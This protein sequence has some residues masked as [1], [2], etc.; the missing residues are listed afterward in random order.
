M[1]SPHHAG[2]TANNSVLSRRPPSGMPG[3]SELRSAFKSFTTTAQVLIGP[4]E[5]PRTIPREL[6]TTAS[7]FFNAALTGTFAEGLSQT[8][9]LP[10]DRPDVFDYFLY[11]MYTRRLDHEAVDAVEPVKPAYFWL[12]HL[13]CLV[14]KLGVNACKN[15]IVEKVADL[16]EAT[17]SVPTPTD[18]W[19]IFDTFLHVESNCMRRLIVD[20]F[21]WKRTDNLLDQHEDEWHPRFMRDLVVSLK[22]EDLSQADF[23]R[24]GLAPANQAA[25]GLLT[26][27]NSSVCGGIWITDDILHNAFHRFAAGH[28]SS[29]RPKT[30]SVGLLPF[31]QFKRHGSNV[32]GPLEFRRRQSGRRMNNLS[33]GRK[34]EVLQSRD[35][36]N[37]SGESLLDFGWLFGGALHGR[38]EPPK[39]VWK[40]PDPL[41]DGNV[42]LPPREGMR[43]GVKREHV[44]D[45]IPLPSW[46]KE[47][48]EAPELHEQSAGPT[49]P[50]FLSTEAISKAAVNPKVIKYNPATPREPIET[51]ESHE[52]S[53]ARF[54]QVHMPAEPTSKT[55]KHETIQFNLKTSEDPVGAQEFYEQFPDRVNL[56][57]MSKMIAKQMVTKYNSTTPEEAVETFESHEQPSARVTTESLSAEPTPTNLNPTVIHYDP[58]E[59]GH[60]NRKIDPHNTVNYGSPTLS[61][62]F[63]ELESHPTPESYIES[64]TGSLSHISSS[65]PADQTHAAI[66]ASKLKRPSFS[67]ID[68]LLARDSDKPVSRNELQDAFRTLCDLLNEGQGVDKHVD[69]RLVDALC[70]LM[71]RACEFHQERD[72]IGFFERFLDTLKELN[73]GEILRR[74][75]FQTCIKVAGNLSNLSTEKSVAHRLVRQIFILAMNSSNR[76]S[77]D[78]LWRFRAPLATIALTLL[79]QKGPEARLFGQ[80]TAM[81]E[82]HKVL[83]KIPDTAAEDWAFIAAHYFCERQ[84]MYRFGHLRRAR[85][86][87][88]WLNALSNY[89]RLTPI[90]WGSIL[91]PHL[92][93]AEPPSNLVEYLRYL[94]WQNISEFLLHTSTSNEMGRN[95]QHLLEDGTREFSVGVPMINA[96]TI[97]DEDDKKRP[98]EQSPFDKIRALLSS[99]SD[100]SEFTTEPELQR[101]APLLK[102]VKVLHSFQHS[103][104]YTADR[105]LDL[106]LAMHQWRGFMHVAKVISEKFHI[107]INTS[108]LKRFVNAAYVE[109]PEAAIQIRSFSRLDIAFFPHLLPSIVDNPRIEPKRAQFLIFGHLQKHFGYYYS[110]LSAGDG[111]DSNTV[112][113]N[114]A[115]DRS[116]LPKHARIIHDVALKFASSKRFTWL[117]SFDIIKGLHAMLRSFGAESASEMTRAL[118][119]AGIARPMCE[120]REISLRMYD[121]VLGEVE[122]VEGEDV[123]DQLDELVRAVELRRGFVSVGASFWYS[124]RSGP[125][126]GWPTWRG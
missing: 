75:P 28:R 87:T 44:Q 45:I 69:S 11:W 33:V 61:A 104:N 64:D 9:R 116:L 1:R 68:I 101:Y 123:A 78:L 118:V 50:K 38:G 60:L 15:A 57:P 49:D 88:L 8:V 59:L 63:A 102:L 53:C 97:G 32:P 124:R 93:I 55:V 67:R 20:L 103:P 113:F 14:D 21:A 10:E 24:P 107:N 18:T 120:E 62:R 76:P 19:I 105:I 84:F 43:Q 2:R 30:P 98:T 40:P 58:A 115:N 106:L 114:P 35:A 26:R 117:Q 125:S 110:R 31:L 71:V 23:M 37:V 25:N 70:H 86:L 91:G 92:T 81:K 34:V 77:F 85:V 52:Q 13:Y 51:P 48:V 122:R 96:Y 95:S 4:E 73:G 66:I 80:T 29:S 94:S 56:N 72:K 82:V 108:L 119:L 83:K 100:P 22:T 121:H 5:S 89:P 6:L 7:P 112:T 65:E 79:T 74:L 16:A 111:S 39:W 47:A 46:L 27:S 126:C 3:P 109:D 36:N 17:N 42:V 54:E 12:L 41:A 99:P 90:A